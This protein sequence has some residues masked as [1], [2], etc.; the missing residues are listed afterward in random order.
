MEA[1]E[2]SMGHE[3]IWFNELI[4][5]LSWE[6]VSSRPLNPAHI[7]VQEVRSVVLAMREAAWETPNS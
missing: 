7:N 6:M 5:G 2:G 1:Q 4:A 3:M